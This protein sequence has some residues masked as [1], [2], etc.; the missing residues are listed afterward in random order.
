MSKFTHKLTTYKIPYSATI[1]NVHYTKI[2][3]LY[4]SKLFT[5]FTILK[6]LKPFITELKPLPVPSS[7]GIN[8]NFPLPPA[9]SGDVMF[10]CLKDGEIKMPTKA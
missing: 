1:W 10:H 8:K 9:I 3:R 5:F 6:C 4:Y 7:K 2:T